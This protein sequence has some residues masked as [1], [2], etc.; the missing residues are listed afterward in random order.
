V[1]WL[2]PSLVAALRKL[3]ERAMVTKYSSCLME[4]FFVDMSRLILVSS[5]IA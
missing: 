1:G 4:G 3:E 5:L 2:M